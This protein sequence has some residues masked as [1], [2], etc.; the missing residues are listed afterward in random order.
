MRRWSSDRICDKCGEMNSQ[1]RVSLNIEVKGSQHAI[2]TSREAAN[3]FREQV[4]TGGELIEVAG[5][6]DHRDANT[7]EL[8]VR[9]EDISW[10]SILEIKV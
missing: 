9:R 5:V 3:E 10:V 6:I 7:V 1:D 4:K 8:T 2:I